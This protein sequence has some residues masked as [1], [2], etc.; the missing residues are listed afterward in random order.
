MMHVISLPRTPVR[1]QS[2]R[3]RNPH[4]K[5]HHF[6]AIDGRDT[7]YIDFLS[8]SL[9]F[10]A[11]A[12]GCLL[13][14][15]KLWDQATDKPVT[16]FEDDAVIHHRFLERA[17][18]LLAS[19]PDDWHFCLWGWNFDSVTMIEPLPGVGRCLIS[20]DQETMRENI[21]KFQSAEIHP[22]AVPLIRFSGTPG[23]SIS[24]AGVVALK[25]LII[26]V[27]NTPTWF[28]GR[29]WPNRGIDDTLSMVLDK[30]KAYACFPPLVLT[31]NDHATSTVLA[32]NDPPQPDY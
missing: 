24:P 16:I 1:L 12:V 31:M 21:D 4:I 25:K 15:L 10:S 27:P 9:P 18:T 22:T 8:P 11:G 7:G 3:S 17:T 2:F 14:H 28:L 20:S 6:P 5:A 30:V 32:Q 19:L 29:D 13:S 26:P 23:Y